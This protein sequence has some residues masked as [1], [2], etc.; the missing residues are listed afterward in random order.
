MVSFHLI[1]ILLAL[2]LE[3]WGKTAR[4]TLQRDQSKQQR[5]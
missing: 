1:V 2:L 5:E 3:G 4:H